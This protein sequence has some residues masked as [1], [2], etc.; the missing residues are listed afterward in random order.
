MLASKLH[1]V[2]RRPERDHRGKA[3]AAPTGAVGGS[4]PDD[5]GA[6]RG[7]VIALPFG[8]VFWTLFIWCVFPL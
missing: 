3:P 8:I 5:F 6:F 4:Y 2:P 7:L 1:L